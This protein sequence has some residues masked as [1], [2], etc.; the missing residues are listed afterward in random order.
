MKTH[1][2]W[3]LLVSA[4][5]WASPQTHFHAEAEKNFKPQ[6]AS[7]ATGNWAKRSKKLS[8]L[9]YPWPVKVLSIGH[10][11]ASFQSYNFGGPPAPYFHH[12]LDIRAEAGSDVLAS[13]GGEVINIEN[14][15]PG[16]D[17]YW[18]VAILDKDGFI[19]QYHHIEKKSIPQAI[20]EAFKNKT[21]I[22]AG[23]KIGEVVA[24]EIET[25]GEVFHHIHLNI[26]GKEKAYLN[27]FEFLELLPDKSAP[28]IVG[29]KLLQNGM[30]EEDNEVKGTS[31]TVAAEI[32]DLVLSDVFIVPPNEIKIS[33]D[34]ADPITVWKFN[35]LPGGSSNEAYVTD[36]FPPRLACGDYECRRPVI[37]LGFNK[38][39]KM[40][41]P[42]IPGRHK[43][44]LWV[45]DYNGNEN[46]QAFEWI[47]N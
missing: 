47:V 33:I 19:W 11:I 12:G 42:V 21:S 1:L 34:T 20:H 24:W 28:E 26:L 27:P 43:L 15:I 2:T 46:K 36:F 44:E 30:I 32:R 13:V 8:R 9:R 5:A 16:S 22:D 23:T 25:F 40:I 41:F 31:Y 39:N 6:Y 4:W 7:R 18:E 10:T 45:S 38:K 3:A 17:F 14:Y 37:N 35:G 29:F